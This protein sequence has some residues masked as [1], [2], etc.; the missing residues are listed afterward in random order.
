MMNL[1]LHPLSFFIHHRNCLPCGKAAVRL[2]KELL[3]SIIESDF[4]DL[5]DESKDDGKLK[6]LLKAIANNVWRLEGRMTDP[7]TREPK[8]KFTRHYRHIEAMKD[9][10]ED[11]GVKIVDFTGVRYDGG[12]AVNVIANE[13]RSDATRVEITETL[14]PTVR[15][16]DQ[17]LQ[18]ADV[19]VVHPV[20][21]ENA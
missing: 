8:E 16:H 6:A 9:S 11:F 21:N 14:K 5:Q 13:G 12:M 2:D 4:D 7:A 1:I 18:M 3:Q 10:L 20:E 17:Q 15:L 19:I